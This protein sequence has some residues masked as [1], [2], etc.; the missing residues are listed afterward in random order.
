MGVPRLAPWVIRTFPKAYLKF[1]RGEFTLQVENLYLDANPILHSEAQDK[2]NY[3]QKARINNP[4]A[5]LTT[6]EKR[7][8][9]FEGFMNKVHE[10]TSIIR[11]SKRLY[12]TLDGPAPRAKQAQQRQRR[13]MAA[14]AR[15][16]EISGDGRNY[17]FDSNSLT[18]GTD[19]M[20][21]LTQFIQFK[22]REDL[23]S[24]REFRNLEIIF[25]SPT[26]PG[27][28]EHKIMD[29]IRSLPESVR[30][31]EKHCMYGP[32][33]DLLM[34]TLSAHLP[35]MYLF[36]EDQ[37]EAESFELFDMSIVRRQLPDALGVERGLKMGT[38]TYDDVVNDFVALGFFVGNDF[39]PKVQMF[40]LLEHGLELMLSVYE[41]ISNHGTESALTDGTTL[42]LQ[43]FREF[44]RK[45]ASY[46]E[47]YIANQRKYPLDNV[48]F[49]NHTLIKHSS[50]V[51]LPTGEVQVTL[52][53]PGYRTDYYAKMGLT[54]ERDITQLCEDYVRNFLW[55][56][57][58]YVDT[59][60]SW[61]T[62]Y[63]YHYAPFMTDLASYLESIDDTRFRTLSR[64]DKSSP[65]LPFVQLLSVL[66]PAS[67]DL[68]P[69]PLRWLMN[70]PRSP[71]VKH[72]YYPPLTFHIDY[73][74]KVKEHMGVAIL[75]FVDYEVICE[76]YRLILPF[77]KN[78]YSR[79]A[80][81]RDVRFMY[82]PT[83]QASF[84]SRFG[85][86]KKLKAKKEFL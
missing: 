50:E 34:L 15:K 37:Y 42:N 7:L 70:S 19:F 61:E 83:L 32:D 53:F 57:L 21:E 86:I 18:P 69:G 58:Y 59:L 77:L 74:G 54:T 72:G 79:N 62:Y 36:R 47:R 48:M 12:I 68:L 28:G 29:F 10:I 22:V 66:P 1:L 44:V 33:G 63:G 60:P 31:N 65:S 75:P 17:K 14:K 46:E 52:D 64:F 27:E 13:F 5:G 20:L 39:L 30:M 35:H 84:Q 82:D 51:Q 25:S 9:I 8:K 23:T 6:A 67:A 81:S 40:L 45:I 85:T 43:S 76:G 16:S 26:V 4:Y 3:G 49:L 80:V 56:Y 24:S 55:V 41:E 2:E 11:P 71:L 73:E 38:R 78:S